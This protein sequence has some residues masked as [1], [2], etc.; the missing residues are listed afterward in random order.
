MASK[1]AEQTTEEKIISFVTEKSKGEFVRLNEFLKSLYG[2]PKLG[3]PMPYLLQQ[4]SKKLKLMLSQMVAN[5][6]LQV[7]NNDHLKLGKNYYEGE[8]QFQKHYN[9]NNLI[10]EAKI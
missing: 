4:E 10:L 3:A 1:A 6:Q 9:I 8:E 5:G 2:V 7:K